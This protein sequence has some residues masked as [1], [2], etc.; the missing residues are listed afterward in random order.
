M[1]AN[2]SE[3]EKFSCNSVFIMDHIPQNL[4]DNDVTL[5]LLALYKIN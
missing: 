1:K 5:T 3:S 4:H 2:T